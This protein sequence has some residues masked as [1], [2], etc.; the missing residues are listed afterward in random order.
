M[1]VAKLSLIAQSLTTVTACVVLAQPQPAQPPTLK[2]EVATVKSAG[3]GTPLN[4]TPR[5]MD[6]APGHF[7]MHG[8]PLRLVLEWAYDIKSYQL[9]GPNWINEEERYE[10]L[11]RAPESTSEQQTRL[12]LQALLTE[13][14]QM[15]IHRETR[16]LPVYILIPGKGAPK[17]NEPT[18]GGEPG[19]TGQGA[20]LL[21]HREPIA[22]LAFM[23]SRRT[24]RPVLDMTGLNGIYDYSLDV[25][26]LAAFTGGGIPPA[27][28]TPGP[29]IFTAIQS[30]LGLRLE[31]RKRPVEM[32]VIDSANKV[33]TEN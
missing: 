24:D 12:M 27:E 33:P 21:F 14:L 32:L 26:G 23:L 4:D 13:R 20:R 17:V 30:D 2:F 8:V 28:D 7:A 3:K 5:N 10:I 31:A 16:E 22:R 11:A 19:I 6:S 1:A 29:S 9:T 25:S 18:P 15:K